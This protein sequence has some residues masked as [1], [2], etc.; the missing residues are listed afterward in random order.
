MD[1]PAQTLILPTVLTV[2][3]AATVVAWGRFAATLR[4]SSGP[5]WRRAATGISL[6]L[7]TASALLFVVMTYRTQSVVAG[8]E[9]SRI[10]LILSFIRAGNWVSLFALLGSVI[11]V[12]KARWWTFVGAF[13][14]QVL[15]FSAGIGL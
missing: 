14:F 2:G 13:V 8:G 15:W 6:V 4:I 7:L 3:V 5:L 1:H 11:G 12:G 9:D 10:Y